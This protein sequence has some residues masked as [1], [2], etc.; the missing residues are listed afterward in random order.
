MTLHPRDKANAYSV[1]MLEQTIKLAIYDLEVNPPRT[2]KALQ[3]LKTA[4]A[5]HAER[6]R[7]HAEGVRVEDEI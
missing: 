4:L 3:E 1:G 7:Y 6:A 5:T 2:K